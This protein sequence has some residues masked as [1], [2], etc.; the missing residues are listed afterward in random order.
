MVKLAGALAALSLL[1]VGTASADMVAGT[2]IC[3]ATE[4]R[5]NWEAASPDSLLLRGSRCGSN[6]QA[7]PTTANDLLALVQKKSCKG[8]KTGTSV[9]F[10]CK[11][12]NENQIKKT[13]GDFCEAVFP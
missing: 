3:S 2:F 12:N 8:V 11:S 7:C 5:L 10:A 13:I 1:A 4:A 6:Q 9:H